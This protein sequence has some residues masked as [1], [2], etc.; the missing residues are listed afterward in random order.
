MASS[1]YSETELKAM[2]KEQNERILEQ[3]NR[4]IKLAVD[5]LMKEPQLT[6]CNFINTGKLDVNKW[7]IDE[8]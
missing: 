6:I 7:E 3:R 8:E 5:Y 1:N 2:I 4:A